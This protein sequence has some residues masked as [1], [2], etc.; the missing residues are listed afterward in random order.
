MSMSTVLGL[1]ASSFGFHNRL[2]D[3]VEGAAS[4]AEGIALTSNAPINMGPHVAAL[5]AFAAYARSLDP[6]DQSLRALHRLSGASPSGPYEPGINQRKLFSGVASPGTTGAPSNDNLMLE[7][8]GQAVEDTISLHHDESARLMAEVEQGRAA[9]GARDREHERRAAA[10]SELDEERAAR[11]QAEARVAVLTGQVDYLQSM[12]AEEQA[13]ETTRQADAH[14]KKA[15]RVA[16]AG[17]TGVYTKPGRDGVYEIG[18]IDKDGKQRWEVLG[19]VTL[20]EAVRARGV[21]KEET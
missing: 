7:L 1:R 13:G 9:M 4:T 5:R 12:V 17:H 2:A 8:V 10:E 6:D 14:G 19:E 20:D 16:V 3:Y 11:T 18:W 15:R 21:K